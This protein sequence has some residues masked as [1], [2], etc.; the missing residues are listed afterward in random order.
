M[1]I[2]QNIFLNILSPRKNILSLQAEL[3]K[4]GEISMSNKQNQF[5]HGIKQTDF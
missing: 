2:L 5:A 4:E 1:K 3:L